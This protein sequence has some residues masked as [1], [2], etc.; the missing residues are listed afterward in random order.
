[1]EDLPPLEVVL[2]CIPPANRHLLDEKL[3]DRKSRVRI[4]KSIQDWKDVAQY[5]PN[6]KNDIKAIEY[7]NPHNLNQQK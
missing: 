7:N 1:M 5:L 3:E 2:E 6:I 4:A